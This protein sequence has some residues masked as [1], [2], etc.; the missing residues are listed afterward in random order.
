M[1]P[2]WLGELV[3]LAAAVLLVYGLKWLGSPATAV[4][5][6]RWWAIGMVIAIVVRLLDRAVVS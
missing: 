3:Y 5:G 4:K 2:G 6:N 1:I